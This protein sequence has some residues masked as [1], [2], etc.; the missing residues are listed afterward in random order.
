MSILDDDI[1]RI[2]QKR[3]APARH[4]VQGWLH[5]ANMVDMTL[6]TAGFATQRFHLRPCEET[7]ASDHF[8][9]CLAL[10]AATL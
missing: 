5:R 9:R 2:L 4:F 7:D 1:R 8:A 3:M 6:P 10:E